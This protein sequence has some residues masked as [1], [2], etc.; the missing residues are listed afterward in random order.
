MTTAGVILL[1]TANEIM[2]ES[3]QIAAAV[4]GYW[5]SGAFETTGRR[6]QEVLNDPS[7]DFVRLNGVDART[8]ATSEPVATLESV[9]V[10]K[11]KIEVVVVPSLQHEAPDKRWNNLTAKTVCP[12]FA[13]V[14]QYHL[15]GNLHLPNVPIDSQH[16]LTQQLPRFFPFTEASLCHSDWGGREIDAPTVIANSDHLSCFE[17][18]EPACPESPIC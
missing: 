10:P 6:S 13:I 14:N 7:S 16:A 18:R 3:L 11:H 5:I 1:Q 9:I 8:A 4:S 17:V 15:A 2:S 12:G